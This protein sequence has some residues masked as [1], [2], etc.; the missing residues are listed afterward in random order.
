MKRL[1][2]ERTIDEMR[3]RIDRLAESG[4]VETDTPDW[5]EFNSIMEEIA[6]MLREGEPDVDI[7]GGTPPNVLALCGR[8][9]AA[10]MTEASNRGE[11]FPVTVGNAY[12]RAVL[13]MRTTGPVVAYLLANPARP[14]RTDDR[15]RLA[16]IPSTVGDGSLEVALTAAAQAYECASMLSMDDYDAEAQG[17][18]D[19]AGAFLAVMAD[20]IGDAAEGRFTPER[21]DMCA[22]VRTTETHLL[23]QLHALTKE[24]PPKARGVLEPILL[25]VRHDTNGRLPRLRRADVAAISQ[26]ADVVFDV[27]VERRDDHND[28]YGATLMAI[29]HAHYQSLAFDLSTLERAETLPGYVAVPFLPDAWAIDL[30]LQAYEMGPDDARLF[31]ARYMSGSLFASDAL[32]GLADLTLDADDRQ[33]LLFAAQMAEIRGLYGV[34]IP[35]WHGSLHGKPDG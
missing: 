30:D 22:R 9:V 25:A 19:K 21:A 6:I 26:L 24:T 10:W 35:R 8:F 33:A 27:L 2:S 11:C 28:M 14:D 20:E 1:G 18:I 15:R 5:S 7:D 13:T 3:A 29:I 31:R 12:V 23:Q 34:V 16:G 32:A 17:S 4:L